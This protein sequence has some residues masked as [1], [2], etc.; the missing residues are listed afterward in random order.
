MVQR[1]MLVRDFLTL[2]CENISLFSLSLSLS[3]SL[4][5]QIR[6]NL[7][8]NLSTHTQHKHT[9]I[10]TDTAKRCIQAAGGESL[11]ESQIDLHTEVAA[12]IMTGGSSEDDNE[13]EEG[14]EKTDQDEW[15][16]VKDSSQ[17]HLR[18]IDEICTN[19]AVLG[20]D[21][22]NPDLLK[23]CI[24]SLCQQTETLYIFASMWRE[25]LKTGN[26]P[27]PSQFREEIQQFVA[28][29]GAVESVKF[30]MDQM[31]KVLNEV[32]VLA[33]KL[34]RLYRKDCF[35]PR[36]YDSKK[37]ETLSQIAKDLELD[38]NEILRLN[39]DKLK[40]GYFW[41]KF[42]IET[43]IRKP[44]RLTL[45]SFLDDELRHNAQHANRCLVTNKPLEFQSRLVR[46]FENVANGKL[47]DDFFP[48]VNKRMYLGDDSSKCRILILVL[49]GISWF[50]FTQLT[51]KA[52]ELG[53]PVTVISTKLYDDASE[54]LDML[55]KLE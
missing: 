12:G 25:F 55:S 9:H 28:E 51:N 29:L 34:L 7:Q 14:E 3:L 24:G 8:Q 35:G 41:K 27:N 50:E 19:A 2:E 43:N 53:H 46:A 49:G 1:S 52:K 37:G 6:Y 26:I 22:K 38:A 31:T 30:D 47:E 39:H 15:R 10:H 13:N 36:H 16:G 18:L 20:E 40:T 17:L 44:T 33:T 32:P 11:F 48:C 21:G 5:V 42:T 4:D 54:Y 23:E 45:P